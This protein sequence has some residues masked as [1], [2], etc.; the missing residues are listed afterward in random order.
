V[1]VVADLIE[2]AGQ[3]LGQRGLVQV[4]VL[5][6]LVVL[7][8]CLLVVDVGIGIPNNAFFAFCA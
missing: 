7:V 1:L 2:V 4:V 5:V 8:V 3:Q 6:I